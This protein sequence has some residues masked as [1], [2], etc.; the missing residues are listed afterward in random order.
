[1]PAKH[2]LP[3]V[4]PSTA[5]ATTWGVVWKPART[6]HCAAEAAITDSTP[7]APSL[8]GTAHPSAQRKMAHERKERKK[9]SEFA[10]L[11]GIPGSETGAPAGRSSLMIRF[12]SLPNS[13][14]AIAH[15]IAVTASASCL[16]TS[17]IP[18]VSETRMRVRF[19]SSHDSIS[20]SAL[21][22]PIPP[23]SS[24]ASEVCLSTSAES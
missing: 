2:A 3:V 6:R 19:A 15:A 8:A 13:A 23:A 22:V 18:A 20:Q 9:K 4:V 1:M 17:V 16:Q 11:E 7:T 10:W 5:P 24:H 12:R 21:T 14:L